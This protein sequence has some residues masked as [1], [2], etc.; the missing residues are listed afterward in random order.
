[1]SNTTKGA[2]AAPKGE[3]TPSP[4]APAT[5]HLDTA[6]VLAERIKLHNEKFNLIKKR[7]VLQLKLDEANAI[8]LKRP[9]DLLESDKEEFA[10]VLKS[11]YNTERFKISSPAFIADFLEFFKAKCADRI[12]EI[13]KQILM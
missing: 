13:D 9:D 7:T 3:G 1:M 4:K 2:G 5:K 11:G 6:Q 12:T 10:I 8:E